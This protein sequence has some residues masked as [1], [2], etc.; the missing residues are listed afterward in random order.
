VLSNI[1]LLARGSVF[2][3]IVTFIEL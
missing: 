3:S 1:T 2:T